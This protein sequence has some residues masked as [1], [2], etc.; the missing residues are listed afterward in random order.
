MYEACLSPQ[1]IKLDRCT[2]D[3][4]LLDK[5]RSKLSNKNDLPP[6]AS[7]LDSCLQNI[8]NT[9]F[10]YPLMYQTE[11]WLFVRRHVCLLEDGRQ[12]QEDW[13]RNNKA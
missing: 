12:W 3:V 1:I 5:A 9:V 2:C 4:T 8:R 10:L 13:D 11:W 6:S 7:V